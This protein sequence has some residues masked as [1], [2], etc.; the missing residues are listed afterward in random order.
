MPQNMPQ[1]VLLLYTFFSRKHAAIS[2]MKSEVFRP[3]QNVIFSAGLSNYFFATYFLL[4]IFAFT[5]AS[6]VL[7]FLVIETETKYFFSHNL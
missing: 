2:R 3:H 7:Q 5:F 6:T 1:I 4:L